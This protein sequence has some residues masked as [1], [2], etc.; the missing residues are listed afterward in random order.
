MCTGGKQARLFKPVLN[1]LSVKKKKKWR[2]NA[3]RASVLPPVEWRVP[4]QLTSTTRD[5][6]ELP[7]RANE[8]QITPLSLSL[9]PLVART[10]AGIKRMSWSFLLALMA[11]VCPLPY[12]PLSACL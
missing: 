1:A 6:G 11:L 12:L 10:G 3:Q 4:C 2:E 9:S 7:S 8:H 5:E